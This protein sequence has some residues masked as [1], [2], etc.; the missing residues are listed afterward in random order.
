[1]GEA[2]GAGEAPGAPVIAG[3]GEDKVPGLIMGDG[4]IIG[5]MLDMGAGD[6]DAC[7]EAT[8]G[9]TA[10]TTAKISAPKRGELDNRVSL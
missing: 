3:W 9:A 10:A 4:L 5:D 7:A 1:M 2:A 6:G 8:S